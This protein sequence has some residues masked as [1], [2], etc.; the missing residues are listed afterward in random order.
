MKEKK[1]LFL[2]VHNNKQLK[3]YEDIGVCNITAYLR[4][5]G[6]EVKIAKSDT[7]L[8]D[9]KKIVEYGPDIIGMPIRLLNID[10]VFNISRKIKEAMTEVIIGVN[11]SLST[12]CSKDILSCKSIDFAIRGEEEETWLEL[13]LSLEK[14]NSLD[15]VMGLTYRKGENIIV[16]QDRMPIADLD[17]LP[18]AA[19]DMLVEYDYKIAQISTSRGCA[20]RCTFCASQYFS[21]KIRN[22]S[23]KRVV[24]E[25]ENIVKNYN[26]NIF[27]FVD[28]SFEGAIG[29]SSRLYDIANEIIRRKLNIQY[30]AFVRAEFYKYATH[31]LMETLKQSG[32]VRVFIGIESGNKDDLI[33]YGKKAD[34]TDID[35]TIEYFKNHDIDVVIGFINFNPYS[36][37]DRLRKNIDYLY[38]NGLAYRI[39]N[40]VSF[41]RIYKGTKLYDKI[42]ADNLYIDEDLYGCRYRYVNESVKE[43]YNYI[44][45]HTMTPGSD[46]FK[47]FTPIRN[48]ILTVDSSM[49]FINDILKNHHTD[50]D[51][52]ESIKKSY[53]SYR[54]M[55]SELNDKIARLF[56]RLLDIA[57]SGWNKEDAEIALS[58]VFDNKY[59]I[60]TMK[61]VLRQ[62]HKFYKDL[63]RLDCKYNK[64]IG[65]FKNT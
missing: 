29:D 33:L 20:G 11:G 46:F 3:A 15:N 31:D 40:V 34:I 54:V 55:C 1:I 63:V 47:Y 17:S 12:Y 50:T 9:L 64:Y 27:R 61:S 16:N 49:A 44:Y 14:N 60:K 53:K 24:D 42:V 59:L 19:R 52:F 2:D 48:F 8:L 41:C 43:L 37:V 22:R 45:N 35:K 62:E 5:H 57:E 23:I 38:R 25:I 28:S 26:V 10:A 6:Y 32:L 56:N 30:F 51:A 13:V 18:D 36:T 39:E 21:Q 65:L 4:E 7:R 58:E